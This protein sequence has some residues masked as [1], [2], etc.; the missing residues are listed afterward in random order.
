MS[1][2]VM[3]RTEHREIIG[4]R[5]VMMNTVDVGVR[6]KMLSNGSGQCKM[7]GITSKEK[8]NLT[9]N[10]LIGFDKQVI[11]NHSLSVFSFFLFILGLT[12]QWD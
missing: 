4:V 10:I 11:S 3:H 9:D 12:W 2:F 8:P 1:I 7:G 6:S 5:D